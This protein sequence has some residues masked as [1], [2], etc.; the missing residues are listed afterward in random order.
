MP[1]NP[2]TPPWITP[3]QSRKTPLLS[4][5]LKTFSW[6]KE[7]KKKRKALYW[8][9]DF[10]LPSR[11]KK[12]IFFFPHSP[13]SQHN[14][15]SYLF[16]SVLQLD[17]YPGLHRENM[18]FYGN[19]VPA[20]GR[21]CTWT[22]LLVP[23]WNFKSIMWI[24][25]E[26]SKDPEITAQVLHAPC[27]FSSNGD[28]NSCFLCY[29]WILFSKDSPENGPQ[30]VWCFLESCMDHSWLL[31]LWPGNAVMMLI[32]CCLCYLFIYNLALDSEFL[33]RTWVTWLFCSL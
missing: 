29:H 8:R 18:R 6:T 30:T 5:T 25:L 21:G 26:T 28:W 33:T 31:L 20:Q 27:L 4:Q 17:L 1:K 22:L 24:F 11:K 7:K 15:C 14:C 32:L 19:L 10:R 23:V 3:L 9:L 2:R 16:P 12:D 13:P